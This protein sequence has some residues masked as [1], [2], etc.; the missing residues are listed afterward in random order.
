MI[1]TKRRRRRRK[2]KRKRKSRPNRRRQKKRKRKTR[3][4]RRR[5]GMTPVQG[6]PQAITPQ[7][8]RNDI[9][10][11]SREICGYVDQDGIFLSHIGE[12]SQCSIGELEKNQQI[13]T[14]WHTHS[15]VSKF[16]P[17][18]E[19][20]LKVIKSKNIHTEFIYTSPVVWTLTC[21]NSWDLGEEGQRGGDVYEAIREVNDELYRV[22]EGI[23]GQS[24]ARQRPVF[25]EYLKTYVQRVNKLL[26]Q[27]GFQ[28]NYELWSQELEAKYGMQLGS[29]AGEDDAGGGEGGGGG[30]KQ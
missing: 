27:F 12:R 13:N 22:C 10:T 28:M 11:Q 30:S 9:E 23:P 15:H 20:I 18:P 16:Y 6:G 8:I 24:K 14:I 21:P 2:T 26:K 17:S 19:D 3:G 29:S 1:S 4:R 7:Q 25:I 5:G